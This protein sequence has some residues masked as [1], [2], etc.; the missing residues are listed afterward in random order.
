MR[1]SRVG[2]AA[3]GSVP[4]FAVVFGLYTTAAAFLLLLG[5]A[6]AA[7][8][9]FP[10]VLADFREAE[11]SRTALEPVWRLVVQTAPL[12][13]A[14]GQVVLDYLLSGL[15]LA[16]GVFLVWRR[17][18]D[19]VARLLGLGMVGTA[20]AFNFQA[21]TAFATVD[22]V[23]P[24]LHPIIP[25]HWVLHAVS[26]AAYLHA[27]VTFPNGRL[28]P[29]R[30]VWLVRLA[31]LFMVEEVLLTFVTGSVGLLAVPFQ[32]LF[33]FQGTGP[34]VLPKL[35]D[36]DAT[37]V[38]LFFGLLLPGAGATSQVYRYLV[39]SDAGER[40]RTRLVVWA[41]TLAF[42][43]GSAFLLV[44]VG[45][46]LIRGAGFAEHL[47]GEADYAAFRV[48]PLLFGVIPAALGLAMV[49][50]RLFDVDLVLGRTLLYGSLTAVLALLFFVSVFL[51]QHLLSFLIGGPTEL[52]V[53]GAAL[54]NM[55]LFQPLRRR[56]HTRLDRRLH[57][58]RW[59]RADALAAFG[60]GLQT[61]EVPLEVLEER[62]SSMLEEML[63]PVSLGVWLRTAEE[64]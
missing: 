3:A 21:H 6:A 7:A 63:R 62:L 11:A 23:A 48:L 24:E 14:P 26:G 46:T 32:L 5:L 18:L 29:R 39:V 34:A 38:V 47:L 13:E 27:L 45:T 53:A 15:N 64:D 1:I 25:I 59:E 56:L 58:R 12:S 10:L 30:L 36:S 20:A 60:L 8:A 4:A 55:L 41:L 40:E 31:Y 57:R 51:L 19:G 17:P 16:L 33:G 49:R 35:L 37:F 44:A 22:V 9:T 42:G 52:A 61:E 54:T 28:V 50:N 43:A 2:R